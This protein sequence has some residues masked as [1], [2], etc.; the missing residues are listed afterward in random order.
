MLTFIDETMKYTI[1]I[2]TSQKVFYV[3]TFMY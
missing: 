2:L 1:E 3:Y